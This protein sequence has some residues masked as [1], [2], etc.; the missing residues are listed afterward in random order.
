M[1][2]PIDEVSRKMGV[3]QWPIKTKPNSEAAPPSG[4]A[5]FVPL[6]VIRADYRG[7][8]ARYMAG[9]NTADVVVTMPLEIDVAS[10][11]QKFFVAVAVT[12]HLTRPSH[13]LTRSRGWLLKNTA[14]YSPGC[15]SSL[16]QR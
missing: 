4:P 7:K 2:L 9:N 14:P 8:L 10:G 6:S 13:W 1:L 16:W 11:K 5:H 15:R 12:M 3:D